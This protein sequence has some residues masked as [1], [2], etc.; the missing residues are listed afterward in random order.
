M[1][2]FSFFLI[3]TVFSIV[4]GW[5]LWL[6]PAI[7]QRSAMVHQHQLYLHVIEKGK[8]TAPIKLSVSPR[9]DWLALLEQHSL[10]VVNLRPEGEGASLICR[11]TY[12]SLLGFLDA[13][14]RSSVDVSIVALS[15][16]AFE[17]RVSP[18]PLQA[19]P[20]D[21]KA[22]D[23]SVVANP[24]AVRLVELP[25]LTLAYFLQSS[26]VVMGYVQHDGYLCLYISVPKQDTFLYP[27]QRLFDDAWEVKVLTPQGVVMSNRESG[28]I[29]QKRFDLLKAPKSG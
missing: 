25:P 29:I 2:Y 12:A 15:P 16:A 6:S 24:F 17:L 27:G 21:R 26:W 7:D 23:V 20:T 9:C 1:K 22:L 10:S 4:L 5:F 8:A 18:K 28:S 13:L 3:S 11:G 14:I 19:H